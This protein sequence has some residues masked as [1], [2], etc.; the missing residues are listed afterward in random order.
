MAH[1]KKG[2]FMSTGSTGKR[3]TLGSQ[4]WRALLGAA[5]L[6][7]SGC[8]SDGG[9]PLGLI[10]TEEWVRGQMRQQSAQIDAKL[11]LTDARV[12]Q[13]D[14]RVNQVAAQTAEARKVADDG[15]R[16]AATVD[17]RLTQALANR[18]KR[19]LVDTLQLRY[20]PN[21]FLLTPEHRKTLDGLLKA[22]ADNPTLT[23]DII[24]YTDAAGSKIANNQLSWRR[25]EVVRR[26]LTDNASLLN[27]ISFIGLGEEKADAKKKD[28]PADRHVSIAIYR[29]AD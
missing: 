1:D 21:Q 3:G 20:A 19:T 25:E 12:A 11:A 5:V 27:R 2:N 7:A 23:L 28:D 13:V 26:Y 16:R 4:G 15:V 8:A 14:G 18:Y 29:P 24:G 6:V 9:S 22:L 17:A 10:A